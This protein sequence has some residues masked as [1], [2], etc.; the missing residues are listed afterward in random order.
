[1]YWEEL[2]LWSCPWIY[3]VS[4]IWRRKQ[5]NFFGPE[6]NPRAGDGLIKHTSTF[7]NCSWFISVFKIK[8]PFKYLTFLIPKFVF[9]ECTHTQTLPIAPGASTGRN[10]VTFRAALRPLE[11]QGRGEE[12]FSWFWMPWLVE[13]GD[14]GVKFSSSSNLTPHML[15]WPGLSLTKY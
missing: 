15:F 11:E 12:T 6:P 10:A 8:H 1:M 7:T 4:A 14:E 5:S 3:C 2:F 13:E 9:N